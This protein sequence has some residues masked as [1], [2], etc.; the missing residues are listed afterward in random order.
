MGKITEMATKPTKTPEMM[1][2]TGSSTAVIG[3]MA[4][5]TPQDPLGSLFVLDNEGPLGFR[6]LDV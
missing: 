5:S 2:I 1:V 3:F 4:R 6:A